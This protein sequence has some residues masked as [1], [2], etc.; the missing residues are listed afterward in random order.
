MLRRGDTWEHLNHPNQGRRKKERAA[1][2][3][4]GHAPSGNGV[5]GEAG[6]KRNGQQPRMA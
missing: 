5:V 1:Q 4:D 2:N 3:G 6:A